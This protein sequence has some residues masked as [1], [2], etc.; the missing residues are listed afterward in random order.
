MYQILSEVL[1][2]NP[3]TK[4]SLVYGS[5][6]VEDIYLEREL[7]V[8]A[9]NHSNRFK[10]HHVVEL[11]PKP[12]PAVAVDGTGFI[13]VDMLRKWIPAPGATSEKMQVLICGPDG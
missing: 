13:K 4:I 8:L 2:N 9:G 12:N 5:K 3:T 6:S 7:R 1:K 10:V 11:P